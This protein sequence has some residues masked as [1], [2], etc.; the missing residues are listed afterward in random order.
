MD[1]D[2]P[3]RVEQVRQ[4]R[5]DRDR[6]DRLHRI[7]HLSRIPRI[8]DDFRIHAIVDDTGSF[9]VNCFR[10][11]GSG[12]F[13]FGRLQNDIIQKQIG[14]GFRAAGLVAD[15]EGRRPQDRC[16]VDRD[17]RRRV[18]VGPVGLRGIRAVGRIADFGVRRLATEP[19]LERLRK[20][21]VFAAD[22]HRPDKAQEI[23]IVGLARRQPGEVSQVGFQPSVGRI[24][25][26]PGVAELS[27]GKLESGKLAGDRQ[28]VRLDQRQIRSFL[29]QDKIRMQCLAR[30]YAVFLGCEQNEI[31]PSSQGNPRRNRP[32]LLVVRVNRQNP[33]AQFHRS[34]RPVEQFDPVRRI[35]LLVE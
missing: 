14:V 34:P 31:L 10:P 28:A 19:N 5:G 24:R 30:V 20:E 26:L 27:E 17:Q 35:A 25:F 3:Y 15:F 13:A 22:R 7:E 12:Y 4:V 9:A 18:V 1:I 29:V 33:S 16:L 8:V 23:P 32:D 6:R 2:S 11:A 21:T